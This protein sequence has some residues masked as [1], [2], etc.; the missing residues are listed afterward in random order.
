MR[1][2]AERVQS[3]RPR[4][5][6]SPGRVRRSRCSRSATIKAVA[7]LD[8]VLSVLDAYGYIRQIDPPARPRTGGRPPSP[9][10]LVNPDVHRPT[11]EVRSITD[12][13][14]SA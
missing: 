7:D 9:K 5:A 10:Y 4:F 12:A 13:R 11:A 3:A 2:R 1:Q 8:P 14:R 6:A